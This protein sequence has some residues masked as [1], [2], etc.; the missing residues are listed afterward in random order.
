MELGGVLDTPKLRDVDLGE[1]V[2]QLRADMA[3]MLESAGATVETGE[4]PVLHAD[5]DD[6]YS[7]LL[8][9]LTNS[10]K[11]ASRASRRSCR[12]PRLGPSEGWRISVSDNGVGIPEHRRRDVFSLFSRVDD[13]V[14]GYGIGLATVARIIAAHGGRV[15]AEEAAGGGTEI[16]FEVPDQQPDAVPG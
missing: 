13:G 3:A 2:E 10:V 8:N 15:G 11:F 9:L 4:L 7:V 14:S 5:P 6:M 1:V 16:W 12:S